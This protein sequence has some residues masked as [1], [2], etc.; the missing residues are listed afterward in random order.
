MTTEQA[1]MYVAFFVLAAIA[2]IGAVLT[3]SMRN[4]MHAA[5]GLL[6]SFVGVAGIYVLLEAEFVA[7]VQVLVYI[8]AIAVLILVAMW[9][10]GT[11]PRMRMDQL[12]KFAWQV[13]LPVA[14]VNIVLT[15]ILLLIVKAANISI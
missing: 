9:V 11:F 7:A 1:L 14:L 2:L 6:M 4:I 5:L 15:G 8:G 12:M 13:L 10:R 3:A